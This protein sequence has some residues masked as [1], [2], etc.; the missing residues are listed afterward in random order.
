MLILRS[1]AN[2]QLLIPTNRDAVLRN[3]LAL[4]LVAWIL[5]IGAQ[6]QVS[7]EVVYDIELSPDGSRYAVTY[8]GKECSADQPSILI[9]IID[10]E[11]LDSLVDFAEAACSQ[12]AVWSHDGTRLVSSGGGFVHIWDVDSGTEV[13]TGNSSL[14]IGTGYLSWRADD[15]QIAGINGG[16]FYSLYEPSNGSQV[17]IHVDQR[18][19]S[20]QWHPTN[21]DLIATGD[22]NGGVQIRTPDGSIALSFQT[23]TKP[24]VLLTWSPDGTKISFVSG[25]AIDSDQ[26]ILVV[27][28]STG[29][30]QT[31]IDIPDEQYGLVTDIE[32]SSDSS[33]ITSVGNIGYVSAWD[34]ETGYLVDEVI[35][36]DQY[37]K[38]AAIKQTEP[39]RYEILYGGA[40]F[41]LGDAQ[42]GRRLISTNEMLS[43]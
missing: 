12:Y 21:P 25:N 10:S 18:L 1:F 43:D 17:D 34:V 2:R 15:T 33:L 24:V 23:T 27:D 38:T 36:S 26:E 19:S 35:E 5:T 40:R 8:G 41:D 4:L 37:L 29:G 3:P 30:I 42:L 28:A 13:V 11:T 14:G 7:G 31:R 6:A 39:G 16:Y 9:S 32:W 20:L 22:Q